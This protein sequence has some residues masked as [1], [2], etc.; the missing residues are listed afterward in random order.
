MFPG[1]SE[2]TI[3]RKSI[4]E[5]YSVGDIT[6]SGGWYNYLQGHLALFRVDSYINY[7][8]DTTYVKINFK[9]LHNNLITVYFF[10]LS[11]IHP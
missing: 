10:G 11:S 7:I 1:Q 5:L 2:P 6:V 9:M 8:C 4:I 3:L